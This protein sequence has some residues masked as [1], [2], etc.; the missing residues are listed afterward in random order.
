MEARYCRQW[1]LLRGTHPQREL[2]TSHKGW[3]EQT[4]ILA[5][6]PSSIQGSTQARLYCIRMYMLFLASTQ[7]TIEV[8]GPSRWLKTVLLLECMQHVPMRRRSLFILVRR[9]RPGEGVVGMHKS[10]WRGRIRGD[11]KHVCGQMQEEQL[12]DFWITPFLFQQ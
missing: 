3:M 9:P 5:Q 11:I 1:T 10:L 8:D 2:L 6:Q 4:I 12:G 7:H